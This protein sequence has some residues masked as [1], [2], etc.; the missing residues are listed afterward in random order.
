VVQEVRDTLA[1]QQ[2]QLASVEEIIRQLDAA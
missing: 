1:N 2:K